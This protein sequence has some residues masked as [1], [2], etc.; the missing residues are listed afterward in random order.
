[1]VKEQEQSTSQLVRAL[2]LRDLVLFNLV[3][4]LGLRHLGT[5]ARFGPGS[6][7]MWLI[8]AVFFFVPQGLAVIELSSRFPK[9]GGIYFWTK[10][11]FGE[12]H[13]FLCGWCYWINNVLYYPNLLISAAVV[14]TYVFGK[15]ESGL[16]D[17]WAYVLPV[18]LG[19]LW[20]AT[21]VNITGLGVGKWL[22]NAGGL[23]TYIPG[24]ILILL[25]VYGVMTGHPANQ[26]NATTLTPDLR[27]DE[28]RLPALNLLASIA[29]AFAGL[30]LAST[31]GD[32]VENPRR[33]LPRA[34]FISA[35]LIAA[36]YILGTA[37]VLWW[38]PNK[39]VNV[40]SGFLQAVKAGADNISPAL[41]WLA[42]LCAA[43]YTVGNIGGVGAW[44]IGPARVA[45]V[46]GLDRYFP[47]AFGAVHP[48]WR[49]PYV[50]ILVQA[51]LATVFLL[52][53]VL[54]KGTEVED[55]YL[56]L[57]DTQ[58]LIYFIPYIY[59]FLVFLIN[60]RHGE[61]AADVALAPGGRI[62][63]WFVGLSGLIVTLFAMIIAT[64]PP[65]DVNRPL[66]RLKVIGGALGFVLIG[67]AI[68]WLAKLKNYWLA[69]LKK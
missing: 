30:E 4:I 38:L 37:A 53:S 16:S 31:M 9:E 26:L 18:T 62:G 27:L 36:A 58:I 10:N 5:T 56:I 42:P 14:A 8:A 67:G 29:F 7:L 25:G 1:M 41:F 43:L 40:V 47:K 22:Q 17:K 69:K 11:A 66:F 54:G 64:I 55:V 24:L 19:A 63:G 46:I 12:G 6:L 44:L 60:R 21:A 39:E 20:I 65:P 28:E 45:F 3:A 52:L 48:R 32:E 23:G 2:K 35:P 68:Y 13:G 57:L 59:L 50:A 33:N 49:T 61:R 15:G 34:V 51:I